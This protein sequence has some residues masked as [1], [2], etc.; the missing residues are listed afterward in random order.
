MREIFVLAA[1]A[2]AGAGFVGEAL[3]ADRVSHPAG[4]AGPAAQATEPVAERRAWWLALEDPAL[5]ALI[6]QGLDENLDLARAQ[7]RIAESRALLDAVAAARLPGGSAALRHEAAL[8]SVDQAPGSARRQRRSDRFHLGLEFSWEL[9]LFGRLDTQAQAAAQRLV[10]S[11]AQAHGVRLAVSAEIA[12]AY[13]AWLGAREQLALAR[14][15]AQGRQEMQQLVQARARVGLAAAI[16]VARAGAEF[17]AAAAALPVQEAAVQ[18]S[19]HRLA[20]LTGRSPTGFALPTAS[21]PALQ[22]IAIRV[23]DAGAW[24]AA[25]PDLQALEAQLRASA[26]DVASV[27]AEY[28]PR[29]TLAGVLGFVAGSASA[30]GSAGSVSWLAAPTLL[31]P[32]LDRARI[33]A[34]LA[35]ASAQQQEALAAY[36]QRV[37]LATEEVENALAHYGAGERRLQALQRRAAHALDAERLARARY[38]AGATDLLDLLDAQRGAQQARFELAAALQGQRQNLVAVLKGFGGATGEA[39]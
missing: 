28:L 7:A 20:V 36:R 32:V 23:P 13:F 18:A 35:G 8:A 39:G 22:G 25:R 26:L 4:S 27:R 11:Q 24:L 2:A 21:P 19:L 1:L 5:S 29:L 14:T 3:A 15:I 30:L 9:D 17:E 12:H 10:A 38:R 34:R 6:A 16:D 31:A 33:D 37:L